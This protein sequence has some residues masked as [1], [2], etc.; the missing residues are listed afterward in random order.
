[1]LVHTQKLGQKV[2]FNR[3]NFKIKIYIRFKIANTFALLT[4]KYPP[5][6]RVPPI[7]K[8]EYRWESTMSGFGP[9]GTTP[10]GLLAG[11]E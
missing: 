3:H 6:S 8:H 5:S 10:L 1:L 4:K 11:L 9:A 2:K 7:N